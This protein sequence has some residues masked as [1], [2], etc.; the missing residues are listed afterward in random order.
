MAIKSKS[1]K[2]ITV[3]ICPPLKGCIHKA[4]KHLKGKKF[5]WAYFGEDISKAL[6]IEQQLENKGQRIEIAAKLQETARSLRQPYIDYIGE[7]NVGLPNWWATTISEKN[8]FISTTFLY[9]C[10]LKVCKELLMSS[11]FTHLVIFVEEPALLK[12]IIKNYSRMYYIKCVD[13]KLS[14]FS[15][16]F[17]YRIKSI[18]QKAQYVLT[19]ILYILIVKCYYKRNKSW[20]MH[21]VNKPSIL[22]R[23]WIDHRSFSTEG[24]YSSAY[25]GKLNVKLKS[26]E[27]HVVILPYI[28]N[29]NKRILCQLIKSN[30]SF[31][32]PHSFLTII[33]VFSKFFIKPP[34]LKS[35]PTFED[36]DITHLIQHDFKKDTGRFIDALLYYDII[37]NLNNSNFFFESCI[38]PY[39]NYI[40]EKLF[41]MGM[42]TY[43]PSTKLIG[44]QHS[45]APRMLLSYFFSNKE[46]K[47]MP[48]PDKV[49]TNGS[50]FTSLFREE[51][52]PEKVI[53]GSAIRYSYLYDKYDFKYIKN[54]KKSTYNILVTP[55]VDI[56]ETLELIIKIIQ[57]FGEKQ[58]YKIVVKYHPAMNSKIIEQYI[59]NFPSNIFASEKHV[60]E[61]LKK[62]DLLIYTVTG[63]CLEALYI[64]VP[65]LHVK[66][67]YIIDLDMF[68]YE[69]NNIY[70][71]KTIKDVIQMSNKLLQLDNE[72]L[73]SKQVLWKKV[74][75]YMF[76]PVDDTIYELFE[77]TYD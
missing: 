18:S 17:K 55:S 63:A 59:P 68:D 5:R 37:R 48:F 77:D 73:K 52:Y 67:N 13:N 9:I 8:P 65:V 49:I 32:I 26:N 21:L 50:Y 58:Q 19:H 41:C 42:R 74:V 22:L 60:S 24:Y 1:E 47:N 35:Y 12:T 66:S 51:G 56:N 25:L 36:L 38:Y 69:Q 76:S 43:Y 27:K 40:D 20:H 44:Y 10:Y 54:Y 72:Q 15:N 46:R 2:G 30:E 71:A 31:I 39:E 29:I 70:S 62:T 11:Q 23:D 61:L 28:C 75:E 64:G 4:L 7:L 57:A 33:N 45:T 34:V 53:T 14:D 16:T 3:I 6:A